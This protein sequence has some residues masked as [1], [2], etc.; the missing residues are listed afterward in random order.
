MRLIVKI[1]IACVLIISVLFASTGLTYILVLES[2]GNTVAEIPLSNSKFTLQYVHSLNRSVVKETYQAKDN[3]L[4]LIEAEYDSFGSGNSWNAK[5]GDS[6]IIS[7]K[8]FIYKTFR[9]MN[10]LY[11]RIATIKLP[12]YKLII[13]TKSYSLYD[14]VKPGDLLIIS[15]SRK[16]LFYDIVF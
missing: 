9:E 11:I 13:D 1:I 8:S 7:D 14:F 15:V 16:V 3:K 6:F 5:E 4:Y 10:P 2:E 12:D